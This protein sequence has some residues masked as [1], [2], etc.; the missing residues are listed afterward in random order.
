MTDAQTLDYPPLEETALEPRRD[1]RL[2]PPEEARKIAAGEVIDRPAALVRELLDNAIDAGSALI[3]VFIE[4]GGSRRIEVIDDGVGMTREDLLLCCQTH[5]TSKIRSMSDLDRSGTLG[6]RGEAL[7]AAAAVSHLEILTSL[8]GR[9]AWRL[10]VG[11]GGG[12]QPQIQ[13]ARRIKGTSVRALGIFDTIPVRKRF[14]KREWSEANLCKQAFMDK[15]MAFPRLG[16]RFTQD[17]KLKCLLPKAASL[18]ERFAALL[19]NRREAAFL[20]EIKATG[21]GFSITVVLGSPALSRNDRRQQYIFANGRRVQ[22]YSL[23]Q[24]LEYGVQG[25]FPNNAH[26][27]GAIFVDINPALA[28]FNI[29]PAKRE[30]RFADAGAI[31]HTV[32][33]TIRDF[34]RHLNR[35]QESPRFEDPALAEQSGPNKVAGDEVWPASWQIHADGG[36]AVPHKPAWAKPY[37]PVPQRQTADLALEALTE[38]EE[39]AAVDALP[40]ESPTPPQ[41]AAENPPPYGLRYVGRAFGLFILVEQ[42]QKLFMIDQHAAHERILYEE[43][44][45]KP[46]PTQELLVPIPFTTE[47]EE[48]DRFLSRHQ[49]DLARLGV[50]ITGEGGAFRIEA[51]PVAWRLGDVAT[52]KAILELKHAGEDLAEHWAATLVCHQALKEGDYLDDQSALSLGEAV[53]KLPV[54]RCPHGRPIWYE[55]N[56]ETVFKAV[57]RV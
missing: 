31:H 49:E 8:D 46:I 50:I 12:D 30:V 53:L 54:P 1:I 15:A 26:P 21:T 3:E 40:G 44:L 47:S 45:S 19:L 55:V 16:F 48:D 9:E 38:E 23:L 11:P 4:E 18:K 39:S 41:S 34:V 25:W 37:A 7:A 5:A 35:S 36:D 17:G 33:Q 28:D 24:A 56:R 51:L 2:L 10:E 43:M 14:L 22:E 57:R 13:Q 27:V 29:H 32:T 52:V 20:H 42:G 6:F